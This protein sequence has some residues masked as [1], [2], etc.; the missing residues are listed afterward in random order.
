[1]DAQQTI[2]H[3]TL[4]GV[5]NNSSR[6]L[7]GRDAELAEVASLLGVRSSSVDAGGTQAG[8]ATTVLLSGDA[9]V[10]KTRLLTE[11]RDL[12]FTEGWQV[13]AG[14][15]LDFGDSAL[16]YLPFS[17]VL[18]RLAADLPATVDE[19][20]GQHPAL[21][22]LQPGRRMMG[23]DREDSGAL[24]RADLFEAVHALIEAAAAKAPLLLVIE[25]SHW[26]DQS[27]RDMLSF[28]FSRPFSG[29]VS[30]VVSYRSDDLHRR[31]PLRRQVAEWTRLRGVHRVALSPLPDEAVR[32][33][34]AEL[35][36]GG[37]SEKE[38]ADIV[39]R[40]EGNA[41]FVEELTSAAAG[42]G[43]WVPDDLADV[44]LVRLDRLD[45]TA[46]D[47]VRA[48]S[49]AGRRVAHDMLAAVADLDDGALDEGLRKAVEMNILVASD[50][51]YS[52]RHALL[53]E[54][55]YDD[56]LPGERVRLHGKYVAALRSGAATG[57]AAEL[58]RHARLAHDLDTALGASI[59][60][61]HEASQVGG[62]DEAAYHYQQAL[63]LLAD[64]RRS[65]GDD[66]DLSKIVVAAAEALS[67][68][69]DPERAVKVVSEQLERLPVDAP[70]AWRARMLSTQAHV[71][72]M[73]DSGH[74]PIPVSEDAVAL[75]PEGD[76]AL[77]ARIL[78]THARVLAGYGRYDEAQIV[79]MDALTLAER[80]DL[81]ELASDAITTLSGLKKAGPKEGLRAALRDA[82]AR[83]EESGALSSELR[84]RYLLGRSYEDWAEFDETIEWFRSAIDRGVDAGMPFAPYAFEARWQLAWVFDVLGRWDDALDLAD[85]AQ[86]SP[87][88][89][90]RALIESLRLQIRLARGEEVGDDARALRKFWAREGGVAINSAAVEI[91][92][93]GYRG[94]AASAVEAYDEVVAVLSRIWHEWFSARIRLGALTIGAISR[95]VPQLSAAERAAYAERVDR[96]LAD[97]HM[98]LD[99]YSDPSGHWGPEGRAWMKR[100][101]A[102]TLRFRWLVGIDAPPQDALVAAWRDAIA[103][104]EDFGH[105]HELAR[106]RTALAGILR[107]A[108]DQAGA[109]ELGDPARDAAHRLGAVHLLDD[110]KSLGSAPV[111]SESAPDTLT[112]RETEILALVAEGRSNGE[113]AKQLFISAKT[114]SVH[115]SNILAKLDAS[116]RTEAAAIAR[117]RGLV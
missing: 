75:T 107:A 41:F 56:L 40:A 55:V 21:A 83:A 80:L 15:C 104:Y 46:R 81:S 29:P 92:A 18:G 5:A 77:R 19:V 17:E 91:D 14:H 32:A 67:A 10:G 65:S 76:S 60:A 85:V 33:L 12:A 69:G 42:P 117:R 62:P 98:V 59:Q 108:G 47:V 53:G 27:T 64:P 73:T 96:I 44:L 112:P 54:A 57:T 105:V 111:R 86:Y 9:G 94:D 39:G 25:D 95:A 103:L 63:Q 74:E 109:R 79:G 48:A 31:H 30:L 22:R 26:A 68:S 50:G 114:V 89:I 90:P 3:E 61:G 37:L 23:R 49:V 99:R 35:V 88:P 7:V 115:V 58:A 4:S 101:D 66:V 51:R 72:M 11:L 84:A 28:L 116:G 1:M 34:I 78:A 45:D 110:L 52:F 38:L 16:P 43:R 113:I 70:T 100:L 71:M 8:E 24:D 6:T 102:E 20:A 2:E 82:V 36:P 87:P 13:V 97:G 93:A 106:V